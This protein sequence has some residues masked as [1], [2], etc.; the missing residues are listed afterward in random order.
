MIFTLQPE[1]ECYNQLIVGANLV[2]VYHR[3]YD[4]RKLGLEYH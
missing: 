2:A 3:N 1:G 4:S